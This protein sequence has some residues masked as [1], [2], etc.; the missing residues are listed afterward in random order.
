MT[1]RRNIRTIL[2]VLICSILMYGCKTDPIEVVFE[3]Q[4][5]FT[6]FNYLIQNEAEFSS[7]LQIAENGG[8]KNSLSSYNPYGDGYTLFLPDNSA[9]DRFIESDS[10]FSSLGNLLEDLEF[11][12]LF[13]RYHVV[14]MSVQSF[15]FPF[16]AFIEPTLSGD[17]LT[18]SFFIESDSSYY[19]INNS[20]RVIKPNIEVSNGFIH[21][22]ETALSPV[23]YSSLRWLELHAEFSIFTDAVNLTGLEPLIDFNLKE[24][25]NKEAVTVLVEPDSVFQKR[26]IH[27]IDDLIE[28]ISPDDG[29]Y[30]SE[31]NPLNLFVS[32]HFLKG[33]YFIDDF[34]NENTLYST[35]SDVPLNINGNG[36]DIK[37]NQGK[38][39]F[40]TVVVNNDTTYIDFIKFLYDESNVITQSGAIHIIDQIMRRVKPSP[41]IRT[42]QFFEEPA[43]NEYRQKGGSYLLEDEGQFSRLAWSGAD[44]FFASLE[45]EETNAWNNDYLEISG[46]FIVSY[47]IPEIIQGSYDVVL[48]ADAFNDENA[49]IEV[50]IDGKKIGG[51]LDLSRGGSASNPFQGIEL[52]EIDI[53]RYS[54]HIVEVRPLIPGRFLWDFIRFEPV[55]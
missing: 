16:G 34:V 36:L 39:V 37:T 42:F 23:A 27:S 5:D 2:A 18:V 33:S 17:Y 50:F 55:K 10:R 35:Y 6:I 32:Y 3:D 7:F 52:G 4:E 53:V 41:N 21:Q 48:R 31:L 19:K 1:T 28:L 9:I 12:H 11:C 44:L 30:T 51:L 49:L 46:D 13:S 40:D 15:E 43:L 20:A 54:E 29:D 38:Q 47:R 22:I 8:L 24:L 45:D 14:N 25:E 26:N